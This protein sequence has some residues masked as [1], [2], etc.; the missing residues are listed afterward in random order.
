LITDEFP[1]KLEPKIPEFSLKATQ[2]KPIFPKE[3]VKQIENNQN[4]LTKE[5]S[6]KQSPNENDQ[7][8]KEKSTN[9]INNNST[10]INNQAEIPLSEPSLSEKIQQL[11]EQLKQTQTENEILKE[12][13]AQETK[14]KQKEKA[15]ADYY[16]T[17]IKTITKILYQ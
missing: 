2:D 1:T 14:L 6:A 13:L 3:N 15:R 4:L 8:L 5:H 12:K 9:P 17:Q 11:Q 10:E 7:E 16:E